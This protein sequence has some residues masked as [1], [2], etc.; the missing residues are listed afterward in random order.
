[1]DFLTLQ[2]T[3]L[4]AAQRL[5]AL[6]VAG[7]F[8]LGALLAAG[9]LVP[10]RPGVVRRLLRWGSAA[11]AFVVAI[12]LL[13]A[14]AGAAQT[15]DEVLTPQLRAAIAGTASNLLAGAGLTGV[16]GLLWSLRSRPTGQLLEGQGL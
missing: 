6:H 5:A 8:A 9:V 11:A 7:V 1:M 16:T 12:L 13:A 14:Y 3:A 10:T 2:W 4:F 15:G